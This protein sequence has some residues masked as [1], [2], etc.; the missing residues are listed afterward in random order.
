MKTV[1]EIRADFKNNRKME[2][3]MKMT[4]DITSPEGEKRFLAEE[5]KKKKHI[6]MMAEKNLLKN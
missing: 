3:K 2:R 1:E 4:Y 6:Y 5:R